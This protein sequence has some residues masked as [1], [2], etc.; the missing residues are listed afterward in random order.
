MYKAVDYLFFWCYSLQMSHICHMAW[1]LLITRLSSLAYKLVYILSLSFYQWICSELHFL[2]VYILLPDMLLECFRLQWHFIYSKSLLPAKVLRELRNLISLNSYM[3]IDIFVIEFC[4]LFMKG[5]L[6]AQKMLIFLDP[7][8]NY[9]KKKKHFSVMFLPIY[10]DYALKWLVFSLSK[11]Q[12]KF[13]GQCL[14]V[15]DCIRFFLCQRLINSIRKCQVALSMFNDVLS[16]FVLQLWV[17]C[18][19]TNNE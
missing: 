5:S 15:V 18:Y 14:M 17:G 13:I 16:T 7:Q 2:F 8:L 11:K 4:L 9:L 12:T 1:L 6:R 19:F 10:S 3:A